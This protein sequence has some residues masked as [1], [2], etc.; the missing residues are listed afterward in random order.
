MEFE[1][2][3]CIGVLVVLWLLWTIDSWAN[4]GMGWWSP[5]H[6][7]WQMIYWAGFFVI[8][9]ILGFLAAGL[10]NKK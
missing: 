6:A 3:A 4:K 1:K 5:L 10:G 2:A 9:V 7:A 8:M